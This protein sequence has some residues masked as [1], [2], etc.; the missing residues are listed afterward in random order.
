M[1]SQNAMNNA[2]A[3]DLSGTVTLSLPGASPTVNGTYLNSGNRP[4]EALPIEDPTVSI[5]GSIFS[6]GPSGPVGSISVE[7]SGLSL[8]FPGPNLSCLSRLTLSAGTPF[9]R[10]SGLSVYGTTNISVVLNGEAD[11]PSAGLGLLLPPLRGLSNLITIQ[12]SG[13]GNTS[14]T[15]VYTAYYTRSD[16]YLVYV[17]EPFD[18]DTNVSH[19]LTVSLSGQEDIS[20]WVD[21]QL[22]MTHALVS[23][24]PQSDWFAVWTSTNLSVAGIFMTANGQSAFLAGPNDCGALL[25]LPFLGHATPSLVPPFGSTQLVEASAGTAYVVE[26]VLSGTSPLTKLTISNGLP[27]VVGVGARFV[28]SAPLVV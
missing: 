6:L 8:S 28:W 27:L 10:V 24:D 11:W 13:G 7:S 22:R 1:V 18:F 21:G 9:E 3:Q 5:D 19:V 12:A 16:N 4:A 20:V 26:T 2:V 23:F 15:V 14:A 17:S 25:L